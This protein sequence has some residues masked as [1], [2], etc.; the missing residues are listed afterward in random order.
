MAS[1]EIATKARESG[2]VQYKTAQ[3]EQTAAR[4]K[5]KA[6]EK[7]ARKR[8]DDDAAS[9]KRIRQRNA[10]GSYSRRKKASRNGYRLH[11]GSAERYFDLRSRKLNGEWI[12]DGDWHWLADL[13]HVYN[14]P[15]SGA[16]RA[17]PPSYGVRDTE[18]A[19]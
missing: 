11:H 8:I 5:E 14:D 16:L 19:R 12:D 13:S 4:I 15:M 6:Y 9:G 7:R 3:A 18:T 1:P 17:Y 10:D 2:A